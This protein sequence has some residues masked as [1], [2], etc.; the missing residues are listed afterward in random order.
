MLHETFAFEGPPVSGSVSLER[1]N[2]I[3][4]G[5]DVKGGPRAI[6]ANRLAATVSMWIA[7]HLPTPEKR[8]ALAELPI[9]LASVKDARIPPPERASAVESAIPVPIKSAE[10]VQW[11]AR[12][13]ASIPTQ[14]QLSRD[15]RHRP[16]GDIRS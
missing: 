6:S 7:F 10:L 5:D 1:C 15:I 4:H 9:I 12:E 16:V 13:G 8:D 14:K 3:A 11:L 2:R